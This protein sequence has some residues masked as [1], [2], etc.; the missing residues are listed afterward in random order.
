MDKNLYT[1]TKEEYEI[2][3]KKLKREPNDFE[4]MILASMSSEHCSYKHSK[5]Y[6]KKFRSKNAIMP[7][8]NA[9][10]IQLDDKYILFKLVFQCIA[11]SV[12]QYQFRRNQHTLL[13]GRIDLNALR[14]FL[15]FKR[16]KALYC[17]R[18]PVF[19]FLCHV[20]Q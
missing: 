11:G 12:R 13:S 15:H 1:L 20:I 16:N 5:F 14:F 4:T 3:K 17:N 19:Q 9:G 10:A 7:N 8:E 2:I 18:I 6:L